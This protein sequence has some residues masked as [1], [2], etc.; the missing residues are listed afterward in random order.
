MFRSAFMLLSNLQPTTC[1]SNPAFLR[2][3][4]RIR[5]SLSMAVQVAMPTS[6]APMQDAN[7]IVP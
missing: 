4:V 5:V 1:T 3:S 2:S 7:L 6:D